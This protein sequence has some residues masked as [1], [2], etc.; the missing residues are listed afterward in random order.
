[1][2]ENLEKNYDPKKTEEKIYKFWEK[3]ECFKPSVDE[4]KE[5]YTIVMPPPN[6]TGNL[7]MGHALDQTMQDIMIRFKRM[8]GFSTLWVP[9]T[10]HAAI[11]TEAKLM[12]QMRSEGISKEDLGREAFL[13]RAWKWK[14]KYGNNITKQLRKLGVS[15]DWTKERFTMDEGCSEAV[16]EFFINLYNKGLI[17]RGKKI[18]NW[19]PKCL[20]SISD[21]EVNFEEINGH[22]WYV[23]YKLVNEDSYVTVAT[24]RPET[25]FG[26]VALAVNPNDDRYKDLIGRKV[27]VPVVGREIPIVG[28]DYVD[29]ELGTGVLKIT[30]AHDPND[31]EVGLRHSLPVIEVMNENGCMNE[32]S[33]SYCGLDRNEARKKIVNRL[34]EEGYISKVE[35]ISHS[36]GV[37]YRC[38]TVV[39]PRLSTQWFV[40]MK[41]LAEKALKCVKDGDIEF[42]PNRFSKIYY[43]WMENIK[44]WCISRQLWWGHRIPVWYC[45]DCNEVIVSK[46]DVKECK[47]CS[48]KNLIRE[49]DTLDTWFSSGLW[50]FSVLGWPRD[51]E[52]L[53]RFFPTDLLITGYD[54]IFFWVA[55]MIFSSLEMT[56]K[57]PFKQVLIHGLVRDSQGRKMSK[58]L[59]NGIDPLEIIEK[60]GAD[61]LR[62]S[63]ILGSSP[64]NDLRFYSEKVEASRN[65]ANK[66]WNAARF[67][68][69]KLSETETDTSCFKEDELDSIDKW[70]LSR[71]NRVIEQVTLDIEKLDLG[72]AAQKIYDFVWDEFCDWYIEFSKISDRNTMLLYVF[73]NILKMIHPFMPFITEKIW[74]SFNHQGEPLMTS[75]FSKS[76]SKY[77]DQN[78]EKEIEVLMSTVKTVRNLRREMNISQGKK[79]TINLES[80]SSSITKILNKYKNELCKLSYTKELNIADKF[81]SAGC[82][83][84]VNEYAKIYMPLEELIDKKSELAKL[85]KELEISENQLEQANKR[86]S[87]KEFLSRAPKHV[88]DGARE[89]VKKLED[90]I[91][92]LNKSIMDFKL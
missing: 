36:V 29:M 6:V 90:K 64:G 17:Y 28:D 20:T 7:H 40:K 91:S 11:A 87:N 66:I 23:R 42:V 44:D 2:C 68:H 61:A 89:V 26:D 41:T 76:N 63:L 46:D 47:K 51:T 59:G 55:K 30:P 48:S 27:T 14:E 53:R 13:K 31:F 39:E 33:G 10:D 71:L 32:L 75:E 9:G 18:I 80:T 21:S 73:N 19:C 5:T 22:F 15:C 84:A 34:K 78:A 70:I 24:T 38:S 1:M 74:Q 82:A 3:N 81:D 67:I 43:H 58:S 45:K 62:F 52:D 79:A 57:P 49:E 8:Q 56:D 65:F 25:M 92:K 88:V 54:I 83:T 50:P 86:L 16:K 37:C 69:M 60:Y 72:L 4:N 77:L 35:E 12:E 85:K